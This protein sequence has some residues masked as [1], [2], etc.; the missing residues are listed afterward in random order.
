MS[1]TQ[2]LGYEDILQEQTL[3]KP[4]LNCGVYRALSFPLDM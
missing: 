2:I 1:G 4:S 3:V